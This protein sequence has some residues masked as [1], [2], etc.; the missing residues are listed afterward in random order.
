MVAMP[1]YVAFSVKEVHHEQ[2][3]G[4]LSSI[5]PSFAISTG[6]HGYRSSLVGTGVRV[7]YDGA[8]DGGVFV[9]ISGDGCRMVEEAP[10]FSSWSD[11]LCRFR[12]RGA[13]YTRF[14]LAFDDRSGILD[15]EVIEAK[16]K[17]REYT[18]RFSRESFA[19]DSASGVADKQIV[20]LGH[21]QGT[22]QLVF[23]NKRLERISRGY[24]DPGV[25]NRAELRYY[26]KQAEEVVTWAIANETLEGAEGFLTN[27]IQFRELSDRP[28][29]TRWDIS[30]FWTEF[31]GSCGRLTVRV[32]PSKKTV[33]QITDRFVRQYAPLL[34]MLTLIHC[35]G[36]LHGRWL[37]DMLGAGWARLKPA[38]YLI[39]EGALG[40]RMTRA[41]LSL[42]FTGG[43]L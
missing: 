42:S 2:V 37:T 12:D 17:N 7:Y 29:K 20:R 30:S 10:S 8:S 19:M 14:D 26:H 4:W 11:F 18:S 3:V 32:P 38:H 36:V 15:L 43:S 39:I 41:P 13:K 23:Y 33:L 27:A 25:W 6:H 1:D 31:V 21:K 28:Q 34:A 24:E 40:R 35:D 9:Q 16:V 5:F 22:S